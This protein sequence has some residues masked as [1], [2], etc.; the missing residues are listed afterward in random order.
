MI[1]TIRLPPRNPL[2]RPETL[3]IALAALQRAASTP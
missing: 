3:L 1:R 2:P